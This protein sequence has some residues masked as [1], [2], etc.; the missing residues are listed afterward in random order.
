MIENYKSL[1]EWLWNTY[2]IEPIS[3]T[4]SEI[5]ALM[6]GVEMDQGASV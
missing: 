4:D 5:I 2:K 6:I 3:E 1:K